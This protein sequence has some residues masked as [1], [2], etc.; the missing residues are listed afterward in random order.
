MKTGSLIHC[1]LLF[2][3]VL[4]LLSTAAQATEYRKINTEVQAEDILKSIE[5][6][7]D[8]YLES[9]LII[10]E[11][12]ISK[13][14]LKTIKS[15]FVDKYKK[16]GLAP[17]G[18]NENLSIIESN[19]TIKKSIF[20]DSFLFSNVVFKGPTDFSMTTFNTYTTFSLSNFNNSANFSMAYFNSSVDLSD[21]NFYSSANFNEAIFNDSAYFTFS[22]FYDYASFIH[23]NFN[24][25]AHFLST[26]F[27]NSADF[28]WTNFNN[29]AQFS[30]TNFYGPVD[31]H[32]AYFY[33]SVEFH[34]TN[35]HDS[36]N[37]FGTQFYDYTNFIEANFNDSADFK[38]PGTSET[39]ITDGKTC[40][41]FKE[42]YN[43]QARYVDAD[44]IYYNYR[45]S[46]QD[47]KSL[48]SF[49]KWIDIISWI[50]CGYGLKLSHTLYMIVIFIGVFS[51]IYLKGIPC[52]FIED[53]ENNKKL[54][55]FYWQGPGIYRLSET[56]NEKRMISGWDALY[57]S[58][59]TFTTVGSGEW[60]PKDNYRKWVTLE[61]LLGW[62]MLGIFM[63]TLT[64][65]MIR[66]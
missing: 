42:Y 35:F 24:D 50:T 47:N 38:G 16:E 14:K 62:I 27:N 57:F 5:N 22:N 3:L 44:N 48:L 41:V 58:I 45:K 60:Y 30:Y 36:A 43:D 29:S 19:I 15:P 20:E 12:N 21:T 17:I 6:N 51:I 66:S 59:I 7:D 28:Y 49:S 54:I 37:F 61:G 11:L 52:I 32:W 18:L 46:S 9:C 8:V 31:F 64:N 13:I 53:I 56:T 23:V 2:I 26:N 65:V 34:R 10:G 39:I 1:I 55:R 40:K 33:D 63:T 4:L 25:S